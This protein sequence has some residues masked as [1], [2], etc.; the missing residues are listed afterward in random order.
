VN[1]LFECL[2][3]SEGYVNKDQLFIFL[4]S[5]LNLYEFYIFKMNVDK[6][7]T[8]EIMKEL[9]VKDV[10]S[11]KIKSKSKP[12]SINLIR[13]KSNNDSLSIEKQT[14]V[15][16]EKVFNFVVDKINTEIM[17]KLKTIKKFCGFD[18]KGLF[19]ITIQM[20]KT[21]NKDF[22]L[23]TINWLESLKN[24]SRVDSKPAVS[25]NKNMTFKP[26]VSEKSKKLSLNFRRKIQSVNY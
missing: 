26:F 1:E 8:N 12:K 25:T 2:K 5:V 16:E 17:S 6:F 10:V 21:I 18:E 22:N 15:K 20:S 9:E 4:L 13:S 3:D 19:Y 7:D 14:S 11:N 23:F 24:V